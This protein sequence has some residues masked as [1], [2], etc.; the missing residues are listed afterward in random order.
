MRMSA[1]L[2][3]VALLAF[4]AGGTCPSDVNNDGTVGI[5]DFLAVLAA[6]GPC[7]DPQ[8]TAVASTFSTSAVDGPD[9]AFRGWSD[10]RIEVWLFENTNGTDCLDCS[11][12]LPRLTWFDLGTTPDAS[13]VVDIDA[14]FNRMVVTLASGK[15]W[16]AE[17][18]IFTFNCPDK[19]IGE[20]CGLKLGIW[21]EME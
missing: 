16:T 9:I 10:G 4:A 20:G 17:F 3:I 1:K 5:N 12:S 8:I 13:S 18:S 6:W 15:T 14:M 11:A 19:Q 7:P 2:I 21:S